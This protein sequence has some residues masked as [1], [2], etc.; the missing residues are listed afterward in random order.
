MDRFGKLVFWRFTELVVQTFH[1]ST[2][3]AERITQIKVEPRVA[4]KSFQIIKDN[5]ECLMRLRVDEAEQRAHPR[6]FHEIDAA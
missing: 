6:A 4:G 5:G 1:L 2:S 3:G